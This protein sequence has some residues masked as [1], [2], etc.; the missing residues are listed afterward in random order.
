MVEEFRE[1]GLEGHEEYASLLEVHGRLYDDAAFQRD[2]LARTTCGRTRLG[3]G[4]PNSVPGQ[5]SVASFALAG[6]QE[7]RDRDRKVA[8]IERRGTQ[9]I[10]RAFEKA[11]LMR[12][13]PI[14][15]PQCGSM[16][17]KSRG[18]T[19]LPRLRRAVSRVVG[20]ASMSDQILPSIISAAMQFAPPLRSVS[21]PRQRMPFQALAQVA[22]KLP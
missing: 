4:N 17:C 3:R 11:D 7:V 9:Y 10:P 8:G 13:R 1:L 20:H 18:Y 21:G 16:P 15:D 5:C 6:C 22:C 2:P 12:T 14:F 19:R